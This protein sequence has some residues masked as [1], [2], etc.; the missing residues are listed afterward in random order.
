AA[1]EKRGL[2][3]RPLINMAVFSPP[4]IITRTEIDAM[5]DILEEAL[6]EVAKAI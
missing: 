2:L 6:K 1:C 3:V 5:F 4:L